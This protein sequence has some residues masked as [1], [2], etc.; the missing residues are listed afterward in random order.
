MFSSDIKRT[1]RQII[2]KRQNVSYSCVSYIKS[3]ASN[4]WRTAA[5]FLK[6]FG[7]MVDES[8]I[9]KLVKPNF[10]VKTKTVYSGCNV[11][12]QVF[13]KWKN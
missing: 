7:E 3:E 12:Y 1:N 6:P 8:H 13:G 4:I 5:W 2:R 11:C 10:I 9:Y